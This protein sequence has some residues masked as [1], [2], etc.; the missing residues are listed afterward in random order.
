MIVTWIFMHAFT[1]N[2]IIGK[3]LQQVKSNF[4]SRSIN[5]CFSKLYFLLS[6]I[7]IIYVFLTTFF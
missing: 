3:P 6:I 7:I 4:F 1:E 2:N 5:E